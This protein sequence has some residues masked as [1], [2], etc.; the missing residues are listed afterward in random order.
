MA[1]LWA[2]VMTTEFTHWLRSKDAEDAA[3]QALDQ[4]PHTQSLSFWFICFR[5]IITEEMFIFLFSLLLH[6]WWQKV[7]PGNSSF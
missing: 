6:T 7:N 4:A 2:S 1:G 5:C 3:L